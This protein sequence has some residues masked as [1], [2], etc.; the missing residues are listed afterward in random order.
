MILEI[1]SIGNEIREIREFITSSSIISPHK[2]CNSDYDLG[3]FAKKL[4]L[5]RRDRESNFPSP[6]M[7]HDPAWDILL[8]MFISY[9]ENKFI[10]VTDATLAGQVPAT[11]ALRWLW[12]LEKAGMIERKPDNSDKRRSFVTLTEA[13]LSHMRQILQAMDKRMTSPLLPR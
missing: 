4:Y 2:S 7:F 8:D 10:S 6:G 3:I 11:T 9:S 13:G 12:S 5:S 1:S